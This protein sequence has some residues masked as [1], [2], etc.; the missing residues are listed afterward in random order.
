MSP[1][2]ALAFLKCYLFGS[3]PINSGARAHYRAMSLCVRTENVSAK[4]NQSR[5]I[6]GLEILDGHGKVRRV[7]I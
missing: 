4:V 3:T 7:I 5:F 2:A 6:E 1:I